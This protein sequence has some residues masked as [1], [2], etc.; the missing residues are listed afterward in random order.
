MDQTE[1]TELIAQRPQN[2]AWFLGA[3]ASRTAGLPTASDIIWDLKRRFY[4]QQ[5][6]QDISAQDAQHDA[7]R[8]KIQ[9][10]MESRGFPKAWSDGEYSTYFDKIFADDKERQR[11]YLSAL[12]SEEKITLS[13]GNRVV[14]ALLVSGFAR[15]IFTTNFDT[16]VERAFA[17]VAGRSLTAFH[18]EGARAA[19][20]ALN[21]EEFPL[22]CKLHGD[23]RHDSIKNLTADLLTQNEDLARCFL[24]VAARSGVVVT[25]FSGRD[26]SVMA[27]FDRALDQHNAFPNGL[28][29]TDIRGMTPPAAVTALIEKAKS[30]NITAAYV[31]I[32][33]FDALMLRVW[34]NI[35]NKPQDLANKV[36]R[37]AVTMV[38]IP[39]PNIGNAS[40][41]L[42]MNALP[43]AALPQH[44]VALT[45][46]E[47]KSWEELR[48][49]RHRASGTAIL[50]KTDRILGW[51][52]DVDLSAA[53]GG[54][55]TALEPYSLPAHLARSDATALKSFAEEALCAAFAR[56]AP[57]IP[58][59]NSR[60]SWL[61]AAPEADSESALAPLHSAIGKPSGVIA[62]LFAPIDDDHPEPQ[63]VS[64]AEAVRISIDQRDGRTWLLL[65]PDVWIWP[66][67]ARR[68]AE[69]FLDRRR[70]DRF[71][72]KYNALLS[73]WIKILL[74]T[75]DDALITISAFEGEATPNNPSFTIGRQTAYARRIA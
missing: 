28:F 55:A 4:C 72:R 5:E 22:Y 39:L 31:Q 11:R 52:S 68:L 65:D 61:I 14:A 29:W 40:P 41:L 35:D 26:A 56:S 37:A 8:A 58:R 74:G 44:C 49:A 1:L 46:R 42:R 60:S 20:Q 64:W 66:A 30:K 21:N 12:L 75:D 2:F 51:G 10:F 7:V 9:S 32:E 15:T 25:G 3:G 38:S 63:R 54:P 23:F 24:S 53:F 70:A 50:T 36:T 62:G 18:L 73:A 34:R 67:R 43:I 19:S 13:V 59:T 33:T 16:V 69:E 17:E 71:N 27:L 47:S 45:F 57:V 6:N 48:E